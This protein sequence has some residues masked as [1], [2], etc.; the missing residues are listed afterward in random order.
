M[1]SSSDNS[2]FNVLI[3]KNG[4]LYPVNED[5]YESAIQILVD[6]IFQLEKYDDFC[7]Y[8]AFVTDRYPIT[9]AYWYLNETPQAKWLAEVISHHVDT[10]FF[11]HFY[12][13]YE[14]DDQIIK[15]HG[16]Y[17]AELYNCVPNTDFNVQHINCSFFNTLP[18]AKPANLPELEILNSAFRDAGNI[19]MLLHSIITNITAFCNSS[20]N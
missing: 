10:T 20:T 4:Q 17:I 15:F 1:T 11:C 12:T 13:G 9:L 8:I 2:V 19:S 16:R 14:Y 18:L 3:Y 7:F 6:K 5:N